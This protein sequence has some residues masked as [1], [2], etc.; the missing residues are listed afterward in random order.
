VASGQAGGV[1]RV[2]QR[3]TN[4]A[5]ETS[6]CYLQLNP[7]ASQLDLQRDRSTRGQ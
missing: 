6:Q 7:E 3:S 5:S 4:Q 2:G 1:M